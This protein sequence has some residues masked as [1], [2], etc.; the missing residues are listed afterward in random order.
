MLQIFSLSIFGSVETNSTLTPRS[1]C[2]DNGDVLCSL[3][4]LLC[5][6]PRCHGYNLR[7]GLQ[8]LQHGNKGRQ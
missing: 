6:L 7:C 4:S 2:W 5:V 8:Q 3:L 1:M